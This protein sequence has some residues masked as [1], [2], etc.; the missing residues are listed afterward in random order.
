MGK[1]PK[2]LKHILVTFAIMLFLFFILDGPEREFTPY[3]NPGFYGFKNFVTEEVQS[4]ASFN[5][6]P[7]FWGVPD[8]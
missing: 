6:N 1:K 8:L 2:F 3:V 5:E 4:N 7:N